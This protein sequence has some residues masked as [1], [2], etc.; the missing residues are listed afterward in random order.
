MKFF[1]EQTA[2]DLEF[3]AIREMLV[4]ACISETA[5][6]R[7]Q[8]LRPLRSRK[9]VIHK[10]DLAHDLQLIRNRGI[11]FPRLEF[12]ELN[13]E[14][15]LLGI[16]SSVLDLDGFVRLKDASTLVNEL[17]AFFKEHQAEYAVL[18][19]LLSQAYATPK[20]VKA[21][22][23]VLDKHQQ[24]KD[25]ASESLLRIRQDIRK[26]KN[27]VNRN[28]EKAVRA[29]R[30]KGYIVD[31][32]ESIIDNRRV[33]AIVSTYKRQV[34]G[35]ILGT[36]KTG[37]LTFIEPKVNQQLNRELDQLVDDERKEIQRIFKELT[38]EL[39]EFLPLIECYQKVLC[40]LDAIN[41]QVKL[42]QRING[43]RPEIDEKG[44]GAYFKEAYHPLLYLQNKEKKERTVPQ[45]FRLDEEH[46][47]M[48]ISGPNAGGKSITLKTMGL[49]QL[50][51]QSGLLVPLSARSRMVFFDYILSDIGDNQS[52]QNQLSTY[53]YR[54]QRM[55][56]F[57]SKMSP[58]TLLLLDE[59]GTGSDPELGGALAEVFFET[60]Y[61]KG[62]YGIITTHYSNIKLRAT[63]LAA[64]VNA[65]M[66]FNKKTLL[67]EY[68]LV[69]GQPGSSFTFEVAQ[70]NGIPRDLIDKAKSKVDEQKLQLDSL[71]ADLQKEK[72]ALSQQNRRA[73]S[74]HD[75]MTV[76]QQDFEEKQAHYEERLKR[77]QEL[78][79]KNNKFLAHGKRMSQFIHDFPARSKKK[80][81][82]L[83]EELRKYVSIEKSKLDA[84]KRKEQ[85]ALEKKR[86][87]NGKQ[88]KQQK[89][90]VQPESLPLEVGSTVQLKN[91]RQK[92]VVV[93]IEGKE[94]VVTFGNL[95][96]KVGEDKLRVLR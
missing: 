16:S 25:S 6:K 36:S 48:V 34:D 58:R 12:R 21:I 78:I 52:I 92:G 56:F 8:K 74:A 54:L 33:M 51:F 91:T 65:N 20:I 93:G 40:E 50:M 57:L 63:Q 66:L 96:A 35:N 83:L 38:D 43:L 39:R 64:T 32:S 5:G 60:L 75:K 26:T 15:R 49:L 82:A 46:R 55:K 71:I 18:A 7:M 19:E 31:I 13:K 53:S 72:F 89:R 44:T 23:R 30:N 1:D 95:K 9:E 67:P 29:A 76:A 59:F 86:E 47:I 81:A 79:Q 22:D 90:K 84:A 4:N 14:I 2:I 3:D 68:Q 87:K 41:A 37:S 61:E 69:I 17:L 45:T 73:Q 94:V 62:C 27:Q 88:A 80:Q 28:F 42:A 11:S 24:I 10:L 70:M 85:E 77:Q